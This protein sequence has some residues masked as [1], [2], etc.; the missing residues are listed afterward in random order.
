MKLNAEN[1][2]TQENL[3]ELVIIINKQGNFET[4]AYQKD[5]DIYLDLTAKYLNPQNMLL[6][7]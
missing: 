7:L 6:L 5:M 3:F 4:K 2:K 1:L